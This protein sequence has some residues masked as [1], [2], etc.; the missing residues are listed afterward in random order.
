M[1]TGGDR[2]PSAGEAAQLL[3]RLAEDESAVRYPPLP[4]WFFPA[5][6]AVV[7]TLYLV[8]LLP[9]SDT[10]KATFAVAVV[11]LVLGNRYWLNRDGVSWV[12]P[13][14]GDMLPFLVALLGT[15]AACWAVSE[16]TGVWWC[17]LAGAVVGAGVVLGT[18][19][20]YRRE[21]GD[22]H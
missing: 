16:T 2:D 9:P 13:D 1:E 22:G 11:A 15:F 6:A 12:S 4:R 20:R 19:R 3:G 17:W 10:S 5:M 18:G 14:L 21:F 8:Q 7:A